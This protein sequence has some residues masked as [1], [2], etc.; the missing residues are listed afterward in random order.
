[1]V[2]AHGDAPRRRRLGAGPGTRSDT[3]VAEAETADEALAVCRAAPTDVAVRRRRPVPQRRRRRAAA[4]R[5]RATRRPSAPPIV[6]LER[7]A[8]DLDAAV[9][10]AAPRRRRTSSSS[11]SPTASWSRAS[12]AAARTKVLQEELVEQYAAAGDADLR[13]PADRPRQPPLHPHPARLARLGRAPPR[14]PA[15]GGDHRHRPLQVAST[16]SYGHHVGDRVLVAVARR[17]ARRTARGGPA[18]PPRR[19]GVPRR[20]ARRR[21]RAAA[22]GREAA[23][24]GGRARVTRATEDSAS[25]S[26]SAGRPGRARSRRGS[27]A[28]G[29]RG[30]VRRQA[31]RPR[32]VR[33]VAGSLLACPV[34]D[35][36]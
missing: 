33:A 16:T 20:A 19:R 32:R 36:A 35:D 30:A 10:G 8:L 12:R 23:R 18:R 26:A 4:R 29:R 25:P 27:R 5:S 1:M 22:V 17:A 9:D 11:R 6:L 34:A 21:R 13:G 2:L 28:P 24:R 3:S 15:V 7:R 31:R 14:P